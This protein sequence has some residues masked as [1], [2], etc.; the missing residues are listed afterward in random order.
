MRRVLV[1]AIVAAL[2]SGGCASTGAVPSPFPTPSRGAGAPDTGA[3]AGAGV[4]VTALAYRGVP[5]RSGGTEPE[6]GFDCSGLVWF[7]FAQHGISMPRTVAAQYRAGREVEATEVRAGDLVFFNA[8]RGTPTHVGIAVGPGQFVHA[9][10]AR[11]DVR[12]E[13]LEEGYW[14]GRLSGVRRIE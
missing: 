4:A 9:P 6:R 7:V 14:A 3:V 1:P 8:S 13:R 5:Y 11:G 10:S 2:V 12:V